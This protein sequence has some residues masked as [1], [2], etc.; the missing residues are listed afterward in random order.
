MKLLKVQ[1]V[2]LVLLLLCSVCIAPVMAGDTQMNIV[3]DGVHLIKFDDSPT[4]LDH[5]FYDVDPTVNFVVDGNQFYWVRIGSVKASA[6]S[7]N[8]LARL[9]CRFGL[10]VG[11]FG[12]GIGAGFVFAGGEIASG[13]T[14]TPVIVPAIGVL[15]GMFVGLSLVSDELCLKFEKL[16]VDH[17]YQIVASD[18]T[19]LMCIDKNNVMGI[20]E[21]KKSGIDIS[22]LAHLTTDGQRKQQE[23]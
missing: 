6:L 16:F 12:A 23:L 2:T 21:L 22:K 14:L 5:H 8:V 19:I 4:R 10:G 17:H 15:A 18:G 20:Q 9:L 13:G 11:A 1:C 3:E 7:S